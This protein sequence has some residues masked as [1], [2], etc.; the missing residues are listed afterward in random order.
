MRQRAGMPRWKRKR[1]TRPSL[2]YTKRGFC[3]KDGRLHL[4]GGIVATVVWSRRLIATPSSVR[5]CQDSLGHWYCSFVVPV[6][7]QPFSETGRAIGIDWGVK[8]T[9]TTTSND[10]DL[11]HPEHGKKAAAKLARYQHDV[12]SRTPEEQATDPGLPQGEATGR[13]AA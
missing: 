2:N 6:E 4:A 10:H 11:S 5:V 12:P 8:E 3:L 1:E 13:E 7:V 9:A